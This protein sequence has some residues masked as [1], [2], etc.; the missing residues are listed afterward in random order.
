MKSGQVKYRAR[1]HRS[2]LTW[3]LILPS[4]C[5]HCGTTEGLS[6]RDFNRGVRAFDAPLPIATGTYGTAASLWLLAIVF[7]Q[8]WAFNLGVL[9][10]LL[11]SGLLWLKSWGER[12]K[13][14]FWTCAAHAEELAPPG[15]VSHDEDLYLFLPMEELAE[16]ARA[17]VIAA[18]RREGKYTSDMP[19]DRSAS[20]GRP[21][22]DAKSSP[23]PSV[24]SALPTRLP[25]TR[26]ELPPLKLAGDEEDPA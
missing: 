21:P 13:L 4:Q 5:W 11:G 1:E 8:W 24:E 6:R 14:T 2:G 22:A 26:T 15:L 7:G 25:G 17:E 20:E 23:T 16:R 10:I 12:V 19:V 3:K 18:R 9:L